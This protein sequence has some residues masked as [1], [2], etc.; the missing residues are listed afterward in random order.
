MWTFTIEEPNDLED[1]PFSRS[2]IDYTEIGTEPTYYL[3]GTMKIKLTETQKTGRLKVDIT[4]QR[5]Q[6]SKEKS[7]G[8]KEF[9]VEIG[10]NF[11]TIDLNEEFNLKHNKSYIAHVSKGKK[12]VQTV[13][14]VYFNPKYLKLSE[15]E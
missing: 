6:G 1:I 7:I 2:F 13:H 11:Y 4:K 12:D 9:E 15:S 14:F 3:L 5:T 8:K 10:D